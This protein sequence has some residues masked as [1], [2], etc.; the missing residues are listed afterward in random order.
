MGFGPSTL[1][2]PQIPT[3]FRIQSV[4]PAWMTHRSTCPSYV[5]RT[6]RHVEGLS[7]A[8]CHFSCELRRRP[9]ST[10][11]VVDLKTGGTSAKQTPWAVHPKQESLE[12]LPRWARSDGAR[13]LLCVE[14]ILGAH[15]EAVVM[16]PKRRRHFQQ[17]K[18]VSATAISHLNQDVGFLKLLGKSIDLPIMAQI[19]C[20][21]TNPRSM[22]A[23]GIS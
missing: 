18:V 6:P 4:S 16:F 3:A 13:L 15:S 17:R 22:S 8:G 12:S 20:L 19:W 23:F 7:P 14:E 5:Q 2:I 1:Q 21:G 10:G 11:P 9:G